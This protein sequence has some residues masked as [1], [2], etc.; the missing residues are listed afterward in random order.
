MAIGLARAN[1]G[2]IGVLF[3]QSNANACG[4]A[5]GPSPLSKP[6]S[7]TL[8]IDGVLQDD[9]P[10]THHG[11]EVGILDELCRVAGKTVTLFRH[12]VNG[13][14]LDAWN[15]TYSADLISQVADAGLGYPAWGVL[16]QGAAEAAVSEAAALGWDG[17]LL[18][19]LA[20][21]RAAWGGAFGVVIVKEG[22]ADLVNFPHIEIVKQ[23][24][25]YVAS[26]W[27]HIGICD[28]DDQTPDG[29]A[30]DGAGT[31]HYKSATAIL[32]G[33]RA[34]RVLLNAGVL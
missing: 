10:S 13:S 25:I 22:T 29:L 21:L 12:G 23:R 19:V 34:A 20:D 28:V 1:K 31:A 3:G 8:Y 15:S 27:P 18:P 5:T 7:A 14:S 2:S 11:V 4:N 26:N 6:A 17:D 24:Q 16:I 30:T 32:A 9:F 33:R